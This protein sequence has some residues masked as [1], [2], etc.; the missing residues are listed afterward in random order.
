M[1]RGSINNKIAATQAPL[2]SPVRSGR[3]LRR[4]LPVCASASAAPVLNQTNSERIFHEAQSLL[5]G[6]SISNVFVPD[7]RVFVCKLLVSR[8]AFV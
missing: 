6:G 5:P 8:A 7:V 4:S 2:A 1:Q 3:A